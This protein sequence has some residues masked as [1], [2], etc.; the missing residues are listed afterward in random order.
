MPAKNV[1][2]SVWNHN[3]KPEES[4]TWEGSCVNGK[5][6]GKGIA[7][8][9]NRG[10][11]TQTN[12]GEFVDGKWSGKG[13]LVDADGRVFDGEFRDSRFYGRVSWKNGTF[14]EG[15]FVN[16]QPHNAE[17]KQ[18]PPSPTKDARAVLITFKNGV[19]SIHD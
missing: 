7:S 4:V 6:A 9:F 17:G 18:M 16:G 2:C 13:K 3:P 8:W 5:A 12:E 19:A 14:F 10:I 15:E 11:L 1:E